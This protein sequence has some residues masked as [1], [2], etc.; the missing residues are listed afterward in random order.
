MS[1]LRPRR[2]VPWFNGAAPFVFGRSTGPAM[3]EGEPNPNLLLW[4]EEMQQATWSKTSCTATANVGTDPLGGATAD[5]VAFA[6]TGVLAQTTIAATA[7]ATAQV[8]ISL[9]DSWATRHTLTGV[10][11]GITYL[12]SVWVREPSGG[13]AELRLQMHRVGGFVVC[14]LRNTG[15][16]PTVL[17]WGWKLETPDLTAYVKR[18]GT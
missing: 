8:L 15:D 3:P 4:S 14:S 17:V 11:D 13:G 16:D 12:L 1:L 7:G 2:P 6:A 9:A 18:E 10:F 5:E